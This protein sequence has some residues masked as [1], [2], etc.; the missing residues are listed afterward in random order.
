M[1][2]D[3]KKELLGYLVEGLCAERGHAVPP[4]ENVGELWKRFVLW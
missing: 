2:L 3:R 1:D 4:A